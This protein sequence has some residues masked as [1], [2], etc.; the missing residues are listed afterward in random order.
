MQF[1][2]SLTTLIFDVDGTLAETEKYGHRVAFN[3]AFA[4]A[5][6]P[7]HWSHELYAKL[8]A[9][10]GGKE[11]IE[12]FLNN[13]EFC[14]PQ[15]AQLKGEIDWVIPALHGA[16][17][18]FYRQRIQSGKIP[19]RPGV[20]R[21]LL[22]AKAAGLQLAIATT[23]TLTVVLEL[24]EYSLGPGSPNWFA[25]IG[26]GDVVPAKKPAPDIYEYVLERLGVTAEACLV[27]EDS[28]QGLAA[29]TA[30]GLAS[31]VTV[32]DYTRDED[33]DSARLVLSDLGEP[34]AP[35][36]VLAGDVQGAEMIT[37]EVLHQLH[38]QW[39]SEMQAIAIS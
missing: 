8:L 9:V 29:A 7:W 38:A 17:T 33:F 5:G 11:R 19:L 13:P 6:Y 20:K 24:L 27:I 14:I 28:P 16:K 30:A 32:N 37:V 4:E 26:A 3:K 31:I 12:Y 21:L 18:E 10:P 22:A 15:Q 39:G 35:M 25:E 1:Q 36:Q 2:T 23:S 34:F